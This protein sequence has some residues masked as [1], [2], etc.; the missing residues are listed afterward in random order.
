MDDRA[1]ARTDA[2]RRKSK[3]RG[4]RW[5]GTIAVSGAVTAAGALGYLLLRPEPVLVE[6]ATVARKP[7]ESAI[8]QDGRTRLRNP[9]SVA[10]PVAGKLQR[11]T[12]RA[13]DR[14]EKGQ[15]LATILPPDSPL[16]DGRSASEADA[17]WVAAS[18][19][20]MRAKAAVTGAKAG[21]ALA[22]REAA[23]IRALFQ[24]NVTSA[25]ELERAEA[26][27]R[28]RASDLSAAELGVQVAWSEAAAVRASSERTAPSVGMRANAIVVQSPI[29]GV[30]MQV[31]NEHE[32]P[33]AIGTPLLQVGDPT[34]L[35]VVAEVLTTQAVSIAVG[36]QATISGWGGADLRAH[37]RTVLPSALTKMSAL[38]IEEQRVPVIIELDERPSGATRLGDGFAVDVSIVTQRQDDAIVLP[39]GALHAS[40]G[41]YGTF[42]VDDSGVAHERS[43]QLLMMNPH[44]AAALDGVRPGERVILHPTDRVHDRVRV[45]IRP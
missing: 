6:V 3:R 18:A 38:G 14:V 22:E 21:H 44:D 29:S 39:V 12:L 30:V 34:D 40:G 28:L 32:S 33:V 11:V 41:S 20:V 25:S 4:R 17:R 16:L 1:E 5:I 19:A 26:E 27:E 13:G 23:R 8:R 15:I 36:A 10:A 35:E 7:I 45:R 42:V 37:V 31:Y 9:Y 43:V 24:Q 2:P